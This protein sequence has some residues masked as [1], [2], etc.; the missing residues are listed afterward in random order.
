MRSHLVHT[1][2]ATVS[3]VI[4][5]YK[6]SAFVAEAIES[7]LAQ[8]YPPSE[9]TVVD[10]G[11]P[12][13]TAAVVSRYP[14]VRYVYQDNQDVSTARNTGIRLA[15]GK[16]LNFLDGDDRL[17]PHA[18]ETGV[19]Y[20]EANPGWAFAAGKH[21]FISEH[22]LPLPILDKQ[23]NLTND[24]YRRLLHHNYI[25]CPA[26]VVHRREVLEEVGGFDAAINPT[27]DWDLY[28][29]IAYRF[30]IHCHTAVVAEYRQHTSNTSRD[31]DLMMEHSLMVLRAQLKELE[32]DKVAAAACKAG[33]KFQE[34]RFRTEQ[35]VRNLR[36]DFRAK[37]W[38]A[39][40]GDALSLLLHRPVTF[41]HHTGR[42]MRH[43]L[44]D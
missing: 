41:I 31:L 8:T 13:D 11:S 20:L 34:Q 9:I 15:T 10:D 43:V 12:D 23:P 42:K 6:Q 17:L 27:G 1:T 19:R 22:G 2:D 33:L 37:K 39:A 16:Y 14:G 26:T 28:L 29:R 36:A 21:R 25:G 44:S 32:G 7:V 40:A 30:P 35:M 4:T 24:H 18:L 5:C 3:V 38:G